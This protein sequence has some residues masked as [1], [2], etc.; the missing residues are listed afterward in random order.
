MFETMYYNFFINLKN[1]LKILRKLQKE[2]PRCYTSLSLSLSL[3]C[4]VPSSTPTSYY[5]CIIPPTHITASYH[6]LPTSGT[7]LTNTGLSWLLCCRSLHTVIMPGF[8]QGISPKVREKEQ[9]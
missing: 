6:L 5:S 9:Q 4:F 1:M 7:N 2:R 8:F 3:Y